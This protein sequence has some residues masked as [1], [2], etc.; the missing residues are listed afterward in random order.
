MQTSEQDTLGHVGEPRLLFVLVDYSVAT[1][2]VADLLAKDNPHLF[3]NAGGDFFCCK[4]A[5]LSARD[6]QAA[7]R[8]VVDEQ[9]GARYE[10][11][12]SLHCVKSLA[13]GARR[14]HMEDRGLGYQSEDCL[15]LG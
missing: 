13:R 3:G 5:R 6:L 14:K 10:E 4:P 7:R 8:L 11:L 12:A 9:L 1:D 15:H 2:L